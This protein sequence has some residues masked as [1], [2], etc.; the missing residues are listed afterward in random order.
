MENTEL[1]K[2]IVSTRRNN[3]R[4]WITGGQVEKRKDTMKL[5]GHV[6]TPE[7]RAKMQASAKA[8]R[9]K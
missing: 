3:G 2:I 6:I 1:K 8:N 5:R 4:P 9:L 7:T